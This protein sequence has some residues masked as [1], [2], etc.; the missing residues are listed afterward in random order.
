MPDFGRNFIDFFGNSAI[1]ALTKES[2]KRL[3]E[4]DPTTAI[5]KIFFGLA[6]DAA[7]VSKLTG[8]DWVRPA[9]GEFGDKDQICLISSTTIPEKLENHLVWFYSKI[10]PDV[11]LR[12]KY[13]SDRGDFV[14]VRF[15]VVR[16]GK[17][18]TFQ[19]HRSIDANVTSEIIPDD[20]D[21]VDDKIT[22]DEFWEI[23]NEL[24]QEAMFEL[25][26]QFPFAR[27]YF[28]G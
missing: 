27:K 4:H 11:V 25:M 15:K 5:G 3:D 16:D 12:N 19:K 17:I 8:T 13:D 1:D 24:A 9:Q 22:W 6:K 23:Q 26:A 10:D 14:G 2:N 7:N 21:D 28:N 18:F 20:D